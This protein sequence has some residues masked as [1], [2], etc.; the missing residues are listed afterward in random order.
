MY[1]FSG[2]KVT[3]YGK[4]DLRSKGKFRKIFDINLI[5]C[6]EYITQIQFFWENI[7]IHVCIVSVDTIRCNINY[8]KSLIVSGPTEL[9]LIPNVN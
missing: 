2:I 1:R 8:H 3:Y 9:R 6:F 5:F 7:Y 4:T